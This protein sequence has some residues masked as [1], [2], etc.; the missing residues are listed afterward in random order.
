D[1]TTNDANLTLPETTSNDSLGGA[2]AFVIDTSV[3]ATAPTVSSVSASSADGTYRPGDQIDITVTFDELVDVTGTPTL[4]LETGATDRVIDYTSG[5][6]TDTLTFTYTVQANDHNSD[7]SYIDTSALALNGG[8]IEDAANNGATLTL[9]VVGD[10]ASLSGSKELNVT[11]KHLV[12]FDLTNDKSSTINGGRDFSAAEDY[13]I[14]I[15][16][17]VGAGG[18]AY[19]NWTGANKWTGGTNLSNVGG[20]GDK[21]SF[22]FEEHHNPAKAIEQKDDFNGGTDT[23][24]LITDTN[25]TA[26]YNSTKGHLYV[27]NNNN[28][29]DWKDGVDPK[30]DAKMFFLAP[31]RWGEFDDRDT[32]VQDNDIFEYDENTPGFKSGDI[33]DVNTNLKLVGDIEGLAAEIAVI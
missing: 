20:V 2:K 18:E 17:P 1:I 3:D 7:L 32:G 27:G 23:A 25:A 21:I 33:T 13:E 4:T 11:E 10:A 6:G 29:A 9:P 15:I 19:D 30:F 26:G 8:T 5:T 14:Y 12:V 31:K 28:A 24:E 22:V 16:L